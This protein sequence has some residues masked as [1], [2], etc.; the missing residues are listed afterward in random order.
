MNHDDAFLQEIIAD[1]DSDVPRLVYADYLEENGNADRAEF[2]RVQCELAKLGED[3]ERRFDLEARE[4]E[5][6]QAFGKK[7]LAPSRAWASV[8][9]EYRRGFVEHI[10]LTSS[11]LAK[12]ADELFRRAPVREVT[13]RG[14]PAALTELVNCPQLARICA[15]DV[16]SGLNYLREAYCAELASSPYLKNLRTLRFN[17]TRTGVGGIAVLLATGAFPELTRLE[18]Q[19]HR[20]RRLTDVL[21]DLPSL[22]RL[23]ELD[24][25][26]N[27]FGDD[28]LQALMRSQYLAGPRSLLLASNRIS[29]VGVRALAVDS[30]NGLAELD[31]ADNLLGDE[32]VRALAVSIPWRG[33]TLLDLNLNRIGDTG[34]HSL[35]RARCVGDLRV[36]NLANNPIGTKGARSLAQSP[37]S[38]CL[39]RLYLNGNRLGDDGARAIAAARWPKLARLSLAVNRIGSAGVAALAAAPLDEL[40][41]LSLCGNDLDDNAVR[42]LA[43]A[44]C[45]PRLARLDL[46]RNRLS[47][48]GVSDLANSPLAAGLRVLCLAANGISPARLVEVRSRFPRLVDTDF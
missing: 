9:W 24:L 3:D 18:L 45:W 29:A 31:L 25:S 32:G 40:V 37:L 7:W 44:D 48:R 20:H 16:V 43:R 30:L 12:Y 10:T 8:G 15:L 33:L 14:L 21:A 22:A 38:R 28:G 17:R 13:L 36:L 34:L 5:L 27:E 2:I 6:L 41:S 4:Q 23:R 47:E 11:R 26:Y 1:P 46:S 39:T 35:T 42:A 19:H